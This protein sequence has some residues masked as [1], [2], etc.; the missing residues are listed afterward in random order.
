MDNNKGFVA[1]LRNISKI[2]GADKIVKAWVTLNN[3][4][5]TSVVVGV[6]TK[7]N[8]PV[9]YFD[10]NMALSDFTVSS[11][12]KLS[13]D[14]GKEGFLSVG[15]YLAKGNR[16]RCIKLK[17]T[18]S[19]GL[20]I[21][22]EKFYQFFKNEDEAKKILVEGF[23]FTEINGQEICHKW[24]PPVQ[25]SSNG[26]GKQKG[27]KGKVISR[28]IPEQFHFHVDTAQLKYN[29]NKLDP[30][31]IYSISRKIHG[32]SAICSNAQVKR[33]LTVIDKIAKFFG[34]RIQETEHDYLYASRTVVKNDA[35]TTGY[36]STDIWT[37]AGKKYFVGK[38]RPCETV[39]Y[40]IVGYLP[41]SQS[42]IQKNY[43]YG[44]KEGEYKIAVYR[45]TATA[46]D[47]SMLE[48]SWDQIR[49]RC[50]ELDV[51]MVEEYFYGKAKNK[52]PDLS[53]E[54]HWKE[55]FVEELRKEYL[56]KDCLDC[57]KKVPDEGIVIRDFTTMTIE[58][59]KLKSEKFF[60]NE[61]KMKE[62]EVVDIEEQE[63][64]DNQGESTSG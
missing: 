13:P 45:I 35:T 37:D 41:G 29:V 46:P 16:V 5:I 60:L 22:V 39:Y 56:E 21:E 31:H 55:N 24:L 4:P 52:Y 19:N 3:I 47:G 59:F 9:I 50:K 1:Y 64:S 20:A 58:V 33:K 48:Y 11:I 7:E 32:T 49:E 36:Y 57:E 43:S 51:P 14:Y 2:E 38:L 8:T 26:Q 42:M 61:N 23:S 6:N 17:Q 40:E 62:E 63:V 18:I 15:N 53:L 34:A 44:C 25:R 10:S 28:V 30:E 27:R 12:D 54:N